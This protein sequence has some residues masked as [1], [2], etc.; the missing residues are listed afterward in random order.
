MTDEP[1]ARE[2]FLYESVSEDEDTL[3]AVRRQPGEYGQY[4]NMITV[5]EK[6]HYLTLLEERDTL[7]A[8][9]E[10]LEAELSIMDKNFIEARQALADDEVEP[11]SIARGEKI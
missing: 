1:K 10:R 2:W 5:I 8:R 6:S 3:T 9:C 11:F 4:A 7:K